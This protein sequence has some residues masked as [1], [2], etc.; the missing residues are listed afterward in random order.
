MATLTLC[1]TIPEVMFVT[2]MQEQVPDSKLGC[3]SSIYQLASYA[4]WPLGFAICGVVADHISPATV[5][6]GAGL[7]IVVLY[8]LALFN[9]SVRQ[10]Q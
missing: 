9:R 4:T 7:V 1:N 10:V 3:V 5:F 8:G 6:L 2:F